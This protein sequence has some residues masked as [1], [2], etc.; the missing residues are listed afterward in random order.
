MITHPILSELANHGVRMG[1]SNLRRFLT[2]IG[3]HSDQCPFVIH[4]GGTNGKGSVCRMLESIYLDAGYKVGLYTS[5]HVQHVNER[6]RVSGQDIDSDQLSKLLEDTQQAA[7][8]WASLEGFDSEI[9][10]TYFEMMT[11]VAIQ[12]FAIEHADV[13]ILE[14]G[15]GGRLDATNVVDSTVS[16]IVSVDFD[17]MDVLGDDLSSIAT[18][19]AGIIKDGQ[20]VVLG[21]MT[22]SVNRVLRYI[23]GTKDAIVHQMGHQFHFSV[24]RDSLS[25]QSGIFRLE[26]VKVGLEGMHQCHNA[27]LA[28]EIVHTQ[29]QVRPVT[30]SSMLRGLAQVKHS[31]RLEWLTET[32]LLDAAHNPA[33]A[34]KLA[35]YLTEIRKDSERPVTLLLGCSRE[36]DLRSISVILGGVVDRIFATH[37]SHPRAKSSSDIVREVKVDTPIFDMG[38][39]EN[40][41]QH[42]RWGEELIVVAG[43]IFLVGAVKDIWEQKSSVFEVNDVCNS[44]GSDSSTLSS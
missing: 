37:C 4:V 44:E 26:G 6:I 25:F 40:A 3:Y 16:C 10:L 23:A 12:Y 35:E 36:K 2:H 14:V 11:A 17:H 20:R 21:T 32:I 24:H 39:V 15:L 41:I 18:E 43:S 8:R 7:S 19:K 33:G 27:A 9:P 38:D 29:Q 5:P 31:G 42:C 22:D 1:L 13:V 28:L 30:V 34:D